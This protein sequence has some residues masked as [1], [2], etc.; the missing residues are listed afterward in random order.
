MLLR[1]DTI[2][3][4]VGSWYDSCNG[5]H[6]KL[7]AYNVQCIRLRCFGARQAFG[8]VGTALDIAISQLPCCR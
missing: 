5:L 2:I 3:Q 7:T 8:H 6:K 4:A 1:L